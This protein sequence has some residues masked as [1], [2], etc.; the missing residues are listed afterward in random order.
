L[1]SLEGNS[2]SSLE[3][4]TSLNLSLAGIPVCRSQSSLLLLG[5]RLWRPLLFHNQLLAKLSC[6]CPRLV[7]QA[8]EWSQCQLLSR[9]ARSK[10]PTTC[11]G[12]SL[13]LS[14]LFFRHSLGK[15]DSS[16][17]CSH[18]PQPVSSALQTLHACGSLDRHKEHGGAS[19]NALEQRGDRKFRLL[20]TLFLLGPQPCLPRQQRK[21]K[22]SGKGGFGGFC[23][24]QNQP[25]PSVL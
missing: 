8:P 25:F 24:N 12:F 18:Q 7:C 19:R 20:H 9:H 5:Q 6:P 3:Q 17:G 16:L 1:S 2:G 10:N 4:Y 15:F 22:I 21:M 11:P 23:K 14:L 13:S